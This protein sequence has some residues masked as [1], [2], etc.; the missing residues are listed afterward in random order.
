VNVKTLVIDVVA[1]LDGFIDDE[2]AK[3]CQNEE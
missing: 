2:D 3:Q 1:V